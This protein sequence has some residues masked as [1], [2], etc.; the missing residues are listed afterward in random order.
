MGEIY[1][2]D[3]KSTA[4]LL[5]GELEFCD[6]NGK[7]LYYSKLTEF[8]PALDC[9]ASAIALPDKYRIFNADGTALTEV[10]RNKRKVM[11]EFEARVLETGELVSTVKKRFSIIKL[12]IEMITKIGN[13]VITGNVFKRNFHIVD[14][15]GTELFSVKKA[16]VLW[17][18]AFVVEY[19][20]ELIDYIVTTMIL[21]IESAYHTGN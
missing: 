1:I 20:D 19:N 18:E 15:D 9:H 6:K 10:I 7:L 11:P 21:T 16:D 2:K 3:G 12:P 8:M 14:A 4:T 13:C 17:G 5:F